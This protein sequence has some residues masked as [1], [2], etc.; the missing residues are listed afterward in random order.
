MFTW[1]KDKTRTTQSDSLSNQAKPS[2]LHQAL[3]SNPALQTHLKPKFLLY[4]LIN[5]QNIDNNK[6]PKGQHSK[7]PPQGHGTEMKKL[8]RY[9]INSDILTKI[10]TRR[11]GACQWMNRTSLCGNLQ[12]DLPKGI[13]WADLVGNHQTILSFV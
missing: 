7:G 1:I 8:S 13:G 3:L 10:T 6:R 5:K 2:L 11:C 4:V 12:W 9:I